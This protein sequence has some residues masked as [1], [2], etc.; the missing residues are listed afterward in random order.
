MNL[1]WSALLLVLGSIAI[2]VAINIATD[3][4]AFDEAVKK[5]Q[6]AWSFARIKDPFGPNAKLVAEEMVGVV[7]ELGGARVWRVVRKDG[8]RTT[9]TFYALQDGRPQASLLGE[10][11]KLT[12]LKLGLND[13]QV[14]P[15]SPIYIIN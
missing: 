7:P 14:V 12:Q 13:D 5:P 9:G 15:M 10:K 8:N 4:H 1:K 3:G 11:V 2:F 6:H